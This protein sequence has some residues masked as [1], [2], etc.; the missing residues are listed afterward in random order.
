MAMI[1][2]LALTPRS[3]RII[4][5]AW[6]CCAQ[7]PGTIVDPDHLARTATDWL[8]ATVPGTV[9]SALRAAGKCDFNQP[10]DLDGQDW[11]YRTTFAAPDCEENG[12]CHLCFDGLATIA[13]VWLN[14]R[15]L[16]ST[17]NM[18]RGYRLD[19]APH[20][21]ATNELVLGFR[22]LT[23]DLKRK[24]P[25]PRWKTNLTSNQ[26]LRWRRT[27]LLGHIPGWSPPVPVVGPWREVR[28]E[29]GPVVLSECRLCST[30]DGSKGVVTFAARVHSSRLVESVR[31]R[32]GSHET[33]VETTEDAD[34][35]LLQ[36]ELRISDPPLWWPHTHGEQPLFSCSVV[37]EANNHLHT[38]DCGSVGFRCLQANAN[39]GFSITINGSPIYCRGACWTVNDIFDPNGVESSLRYD[40]QLARNAG[41]NM[42]RVG[43]TM[44]YESD[45]FYRLCDEL[46]ILVWQDFMFANM[47]YPVEDESFAGNIAAEARQQLNRLAA[48]P[49]LAVYC[50][51]SEIEQQAA[52]LGMPRELWRNRWFAEQLPA[53]CAELH[54][55]T[56]YV[57]STPSGGS[58]PF[59]TGTGISHYYGIG[60]YLRSPME[61]RSANVNFTPECL[62]F[63]NV[64]EPETIDALM[65]GALPAMHHPKWKQRVPRDTGAGWDFEDVRDFY[66]RYLYELDPVQLRSFDTNR[67]LQLSRV[68][69]GEM[70]AQTFAEWRSGHSQNRGGLVWFFKD[71][72][73][74][75]GWGIVDSTG[76]PKA[77]Y[78]YLRRTWQS[79]QIVLTD[80][81]LNGLHF[82][83]INELAEPL[84]GFVEVTLLR[85]PSLTVARSEVPIE[86]GS[87]SQKMFCADELLGGF[88]DVN[89]AYRFGPPHHDVVI[90]TL[91]DTEHQVISE[92]CYFTRRREPTPSRG[93][94]LESTVQKTSGTEYQVTLNS[95]RFLHGVHLSAKG[96]LPND[97]YF[98]L[99]PS[100]SKTVV[101][102]ALGTSAGLFKMTVEALNS[103]DTLSIA[104]G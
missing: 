3:T 77:A 70:M 95:D 66:L 49:C 86:I 101:F 82:H 19:I 20:L 103:D 42:L 54:P 74:G 88:H 97:N 90:A 36:G 33:V 43:G 24:R 29:T 67:Y 85:E 84:S 27:S 38:F 57:P 23:E 76:L 11:W 92:A 94:A 5:D 40:L 78:Y 51:N 16:L 4:L 31:L 52:M 89:H 75:A 37:I 50:G 102:S 104:A 28:I 63:A 13:D 7:P 61:L 55:G 62:G 80:E 46:G 45:A 71:L 81:G 34:G 9:A 72:W 56:A 6:S 87:R 99:P 59:H 12:L 64:P 18:F 83:A 65:Q 8:P 44:T 39:D 35:L 79:R 48:H 2:E 69:S 30:V 14:G 41:M 47:D 73:P 21:Q 15:L 98:H 68:A 93:L 26:Q 58:L 91:Y 17:D 25:R 96:Y 53:L 60:A 22:S 100:R 1:T 10:I 32:V